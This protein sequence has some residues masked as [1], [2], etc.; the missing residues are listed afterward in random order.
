MANLDSERLVRAYR[1]K[2]CS[3]S[4]GLE[5]SLAI[6]CIQFSRSKGNSSFTWISRQL[7]LESVK[8]AGGPHFRQFFM[9][10]KRISHGIEYGHYCSPILMSR[11]SIENKNSMQAPTKSS[12]RAMELWEYPR[13]IDILFEGAGALGSRPEKADAEALE[14]HLWRTRIPPPVKHFGSHLKSRIAIQ[15][16]NMQWQPECVW[17]RYR[18]DSGQI[19]PNATGCRTRTSENSHSTPSSN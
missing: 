2:W 5:F 9:C 16:H 3:L 12:G 14:R 15:R 11:N 18:G 1:L 7:L 13:H 4:V 19:G 10:D 17:P 6:L 8:S